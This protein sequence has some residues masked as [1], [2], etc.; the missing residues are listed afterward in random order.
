[1]DA[2]LHNPYI[3]LKYTKYAIHILFIDRKNILKNS[4][5]VKSPLAFY[6]WFCNLHEYNLQEIIF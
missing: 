2:I 5:K 4:L 3:H 6:F 1:M